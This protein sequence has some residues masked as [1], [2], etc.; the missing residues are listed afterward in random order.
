MKN[1][2]LKNILLFAI[3]FLAV[4]GLFST[5]NMQATKIETKDIAT[6]VNQIEGDLVK[7]IDIEDNRLL[8][9]LKTDVKEEI[10]KEPQ[11]S[12][13]TLL[14]NYSVTPE[15]IKAVSIQ[16]KERSGLSYWL[17][18]ILPFVLPFIIIG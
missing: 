18:T 3:I 1:P 12:L 6:L 17:E 2:L 11:D 9:T 13:S 7:S 16:V 5:Y 15:K 14:K 10:L 8:V 4:A